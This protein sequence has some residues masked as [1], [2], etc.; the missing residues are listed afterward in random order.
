MPI[1][2]SWAEWQAITLAVVSLMFSLVSLA[3]MIGTGFH[4]PKLQGWAKDELYQALASLLLA[5]LL[6]TFISTIDTTMSSIYGKDPFDIAR[7]Y[8]NTVT[9][10]LGTF[11]T[12]FVAYD[13]YFQL[14]KS[15]VLKAMPSQ[16]GFDIN[17]LIGLAPLTAMLSLS[18]EATLGAMA[19]LFGMSAFISF[20]QYQLSIIL[21]IGMVLRAFPFSRSAGGALIAVFLGFYVFYPFF[22]VFDSYIY[23]D[24]TAAMYAFP[25]ANTATTALGIG[26]ECIQCPMCCV[27]NV[28][29]LSGNMFLSI[30]MNLTYPV[31]YYIFILALL[32]PIFNLIM[33]LILI[34]ELAKIFGSEIDITGLS[35]LI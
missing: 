20:I 18:I 25:L 9:A 4:L 11:F 22:W 8:V 23:S 7:D 26:S 16:T 15:A 35:G 6:I 5:V 29:D 34:N 3:Y 30:I 12:G 32:L 10:G 2:V 28:P 14:F 13:V 24:V 17:P 33:V 1:V 21:P 31:I 27:A 19:L